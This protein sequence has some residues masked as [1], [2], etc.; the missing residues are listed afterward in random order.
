MTKRDK[1]T[2]P[3]VQC[4]ALTLPCLLA[5]PSSWFRATTKNPGS[6]VMIIGVGACKHDSNIQIPDYRTGIRKCFV[7][8]YQELDPAAS[9]NIRQDCGRSNAFSRGE[10]SIFG[11][12]NAVETKQDKP[13]KTARVKP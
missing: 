10:Y 6:R 5:S 7:W 3:S 9:R 1:G 8:M 13:S 4:P 11:L 12:A 2:K